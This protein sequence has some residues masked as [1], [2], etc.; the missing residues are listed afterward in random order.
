M[1]WLS[2]YCKDFSSHEVKSMRYSWGGLE[3]DVLSG[4]VTRVLTREPCQNKQS[5]E[6]RKVALEAHFKSVLL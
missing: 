2:Y 6:Q 4:I 5:L 1:S 3:G